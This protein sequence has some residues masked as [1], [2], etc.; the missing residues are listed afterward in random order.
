MSQPFHFHLKSF[1]FVLFFYFWNGSVKKKCAIFRPL[2]QHVCVLSCHTQRP[3]LMIIID[4]KTKREHRMAFT[5]CK[6][7][8]L[9]IFY[10]CALCVV[11]AHNTH[12]KLTLMLLFAITHI[13]PQNLMAQSLL[14]PLPPS[15]SSPS[16]P[17]AK[18][19]HF[20]QVCDARVHHKCDSFK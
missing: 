17:H 18:T 10:T 7:E 9:Y 3:N 5:I 12:M 15:P 4:A 13:R 20:N 19:I 11:R 16:L 1:Y 2:P 14:S 8:Q 6:N